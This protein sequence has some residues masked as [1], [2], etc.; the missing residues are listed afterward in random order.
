[1]PSSK[2]RM[3]GFWKLG[4]ASLLVVGAACGESADDATTEAV[5]A[6]ADCAFAFNE[7]TLAERSWAFDGTLTAVST[8]T[9]SQLGGVPTASFTVNRWYKG[10]S[11]DEVTVQYEQGPISEYAPTADAG[12]RLLVT[13]EPR[14]GGE[15]LEDAVAWGCGFTQRWTPSAAEQWS[16]VFGA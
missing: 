3:Q 12:A 11:G 15:P 9:D 5:T 13:G 6:E 10:G 8:G 4:L 2:R 16:I 7:G 1:M 14:W